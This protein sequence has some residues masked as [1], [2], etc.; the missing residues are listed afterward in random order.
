MIENINIQ[1]LVQDY[2]VPW[3][4]NIVLA[5]AIFVIGRMAAKMIVTLIRKI[6]VRIELDAILINFV[7]SILKAVL[8]VLVIVAALD[9]LGVDTTSLIAVLGAAGLAVAL[10]LQDSLKNFAA[11]VLLII[12]RPFRTGHYVEAGGVAGVVEKINIFSSTFSTGDNCEIII[13]NGAIY[14]DVITNYSVRDTR[15][16]DMVFGIGYGDDLRKAKEIIAAILADEER[17]LADPEP[18]IAV[19]ELADSS[20]NII[21]RPWVKNDDYWPVN[22]DLLER[23]KLAFDDNGISI[24]YPQM[25]VHMDKSG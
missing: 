7:S 4:I 6:L 20:V 12:F 13:P 23:I 3:G 18:L 24:P 15:R 22:R 14:G 5:L 11:G 2:A 1:E 17:I 8:L 16:I 21:V 25:D 19:G 10:A 9:Q